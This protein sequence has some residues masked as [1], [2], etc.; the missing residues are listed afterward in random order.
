MAT[1]TQRREGGLV[2]TDA[3]TGGTWPRAEEAR[4]PPGAGT[5][6]KGLPPEPLEHGPAAA[7]ILVFWPNCETTNLCCFKPP[8]LWHLAVA[9]A[10]SDHTWQRRARGG[11]GRAARGSWGP[12]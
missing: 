9:A 4:E 3:E 1:E 12:R 11:G 8:I 7:L 10:G 5:G 6:G 2:Q